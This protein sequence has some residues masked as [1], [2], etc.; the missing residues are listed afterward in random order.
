LVRLE[1]VAV[2]VSGHL[3]AMVDPE[4]RV[5]TFRW[6]IL[7][8]GLAARKFVL[9]LRAAQAARVVV[10]GSRSQ[11]KA[12]EF[13]RGFGIPRA[14]ASYERA[15]CDGDVDA[16]YVATPASLHREHALLCLNAGKPVL[17]EKPFAVTAAQARDVVDAA[18]ARSL[19]C[20]EGMWTRFLPLVRRAR[21]MLDAG[22]VGDVRLLTGSFGIAERVD[23]Q[24]GLFDPDLGGGALLD[25]G[26]YLISL[27]LHFLGPAGEILS[28][29]VIGGTGV[30][31]D[32]AVTLRHRRG[33][34]AVLHASLRTQCSND[35]VIM[36]T[37]AQIR[38]Q[39]P[40]Y[41]P[42]RMT[43][44]PVVARARDVSI[45]PGSE[46]LRE[47]RWIH[48]ALQRLSRI[49]TPL[50]NRHAK[51]LL[52]PYGGNGY[53]HE[54]DEVM[55]CVSEGRI[56]STVMPLTESLQVMET[57]DAIRAQWARTAPPGAGD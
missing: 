51:E 54:A 48:G 6:G 42:F 55:R 3:D 36:G 26:V 37:R 7:G 53:H 41:R 46:A 17:V 25:R 29:A 35:L 56:E 19:F 16:F 47:S 33:G 50:R 12:L 14:H 20:M 22:A 21:S 43:L 38:L 34:L 10:V 30:D 9:G 15:V 40:I 24:S 57:V 44:T 32:V 52:E 45:R 2:A 23:A 49:A 11:E 8:T 1:N 28:D 13:A 18:R 39:A 5:K 4:T 27:A 31:E